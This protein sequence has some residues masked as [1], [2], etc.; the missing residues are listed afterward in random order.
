ME[1]DSIRHAGR[2]NPVASVAVL[3]AGT[4]LMACVQETPTDVGGT[5]LPGG[6]RT[7]EVFLEPSRFAV[8][9]T[10]FGGYTDLQAS[11]LLLL[12][13]AFD[14]VVDAN[15][16][17]RLTMPV[18]INV[19]DATGNTVTDSMP[20]FFGGR[21]VIGL[22]TLASAGPAS[23]N[24]RLSRLAE[25]YD[26]GTATWTLRADTSDVEVPWTTPGGAPGDVVNTWTWQ[27]GSDSLVIPIDSA[28]IA[29][30]TDTLATVK[31][32]V[33]ELETPNTRLRPTR[34]ALQVDARSSIDTDTTVTVAAT[35]TAVLSLITPLVSGTASHI[36]VGGTPGWR[37]MLRM[38]ERL[39]TL[40]IPCLDGA[41]G[42]TVTLGEA[43]V[44]AA[45]LIFEPTASPAGYALESSLLIGVRELIVRSGIPLERSPLGSV[46]GSTSRPLLPGALQPGPGRTVELPITEYIR[47]FTDGDDDYP[48]AWLAIAGSPEGGTF[49][50]ATFADL[51]RLRLIV[52]VGTELQLR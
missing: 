6:V 19:R 38:R 24:L 15:I 11:G 48:S 4:L 39:D 14:G 16:V 37:G 17:G 28:A 10:A 44:T 7:Y 47:R 50:F 30:W 13:E 52:S 46:V 2:V 42:C 32:F 25:Q 41:P 45:S 34:I 23:A 18:S 12:A 1:R 8:G 43:S 33:L 40:R 22:D 3:L 36:R 26:P 49:G 9:D 27:P 51:P 31:G 20:V 5:L 21:F 35:A 29:A